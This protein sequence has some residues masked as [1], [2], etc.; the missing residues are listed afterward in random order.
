VLSQ[1]H[2]IPIYAWVRTQAAEVISS[3]AVQKN[4][5]FPGLGL[6][7]PSYSALTALLYFS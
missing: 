3:H 7:V 1:Q 6:D 2:C 5:R 4:P